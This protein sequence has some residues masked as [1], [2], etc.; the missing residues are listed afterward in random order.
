MKVYIYAYI[1]KIN[2]H[3]YIGKTNNLARRMREHKSMAY[4]PNSH[5]YNSLWS[6]KI[7]EYGYDNFEVKIL[8]ICDYSQWQEREKYWIKYYNTFN[9]VGYNTTPGGEDEDNC[10]NRILTNEEAIL[11]YNDLLNSSM[12]QKDIAY[13]YDISQTLL[14][15]IN[16]GL[17]YTSNE[18]GYQQNVIYPLRKNYKTEN[19]YEELYNLLRNS[20]L[21]FREIAQQLHMG[22]ST[23]KKINYGT[24]RHDNAK[25]YPIRKYTRIDMIGNNGHN[26]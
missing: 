11:I 14:S 16:L 10:L 13:K 23:V 2:G 8:E 9:G 26:N 22:E 1:N 3:M 15:N 21:S 17:K 19:D 24:L 25:I 20:T 12:K 5:M 6:K 18:I 7:R 4:N